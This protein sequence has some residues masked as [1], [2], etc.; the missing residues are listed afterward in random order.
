LEASARPSAC[1]LA[2]GQRDG[3]LLPAGRDLQQFDGERDEFVQG[4][5]A[6]A[7]GRRFAERVRDAGAGAQRRILGDADLARDDVGRQEADAADVA[8]EP[9]GVFLDD[10]DGVRTVGLEDAHGA[11]GRHAVA[12]QEHHDLGDDLLVGP[13]GGDLAGELVA[14]AGDLAQPLGRLLD[15]LEHVLA[16]GLHERPAYTGPMPLTMPEPR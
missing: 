12:V 6:V 2:V 1:F 9:V 15:D 14:D 3:Q 8:G 7:L 13:A 5:S 11:R 4:E 16:E 10:G